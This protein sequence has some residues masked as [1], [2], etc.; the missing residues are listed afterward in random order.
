VS[1]YR[2]YR[3]RLESDHTLDI[4]KMDNIALILAFIQAAFRAEH[5]VNLTEGAVVERLTALLEEINASE[6]KPLFEKPASY[7]LDYWAREGVLSR[8]H[9]ETLEIVYS[10]TPAAERAHGF[11]QGIERKT[12]VGAE[13]KIKLIASTLQDLAENSDT[14]VDRRIA[15]IERRITELREEQHSLNLGTP[16]KLYSAVEK[17]ERYRL[18]IDLGRDLQRDFGL[19]RERFKVMARTV[20]EQ[21]SATG[22]NRGDV[23]RRA[24][25]D[26]AILRRSPEGQSFSAFQLFLLD[27]QSQRD[28]QKLVEE[29]ET[30]PEIDPAEKKGRFLRDR[31]H[32]GKV[33]RT[34]FHP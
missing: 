32:Q 14:D 18:A 33:R 20:A 28:L 27:P 10:L 19:I 13:S 4:L 16:P 17:Q 6:E 5:A 7:Y 30:L 31:P 24:L 1:T 34:C 26:D 2:Q 9:T 22:V 21:Y 23:L 12:S 8:R 3:L 29:V 25:E 15:L 11:A